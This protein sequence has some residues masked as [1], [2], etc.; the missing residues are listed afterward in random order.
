MFQ[1][2]QT[3]RTGRSRRNRDSSNSQ[4]RSGAVTRATSQAG[5]SSASQGDL[6]SPTVGPYSEQ[7]MSAVK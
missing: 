2:T 4:L 1:G 5:S 7:S 6:N 3:R